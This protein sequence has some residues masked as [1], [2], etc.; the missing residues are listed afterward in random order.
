[1]ARSRDSLDMDNNEK[2]EQTDL[3]IEDGDNF[4]QI[5]ARITFSFLHLIQSIY[6]FT[7]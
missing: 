3:D 7:L 2:A 5:K 4:K 6:V 1:M